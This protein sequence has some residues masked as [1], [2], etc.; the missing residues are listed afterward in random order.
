MS[1]PP[2]P[3][4]VPAT[5]LPDAEARSLLRA[6]PAGDGLEAWLVDQPWHAAIDGSWLV[7]RDRE[8]WTYRVEGVPG[9]VVWVIA[10]SPES[11]SITSW[12]VAP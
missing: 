12:L 9:R 4:A 7:E 11:G 3:A 5:V 10:R 6:H 2:D 8:G 1:M